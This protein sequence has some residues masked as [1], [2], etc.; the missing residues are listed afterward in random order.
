MRP[1]TTVVLVEDH[2]ALREGIKLLL[3]YRGHVIAGAAGDARSGGELIRAKRPDVA[4]VDIRLPDASGAQ[5]TRELLEDDPELGVLIY[6]GIG[7]EEELGEALACGARGF[8]LKSGS[9]E[10]L[11]AAIHA[12]AA[13]GTYM[14]P[15]LAPSLLARLEANSAHDLSPREREILELLADGLTGAQVAQLLFVSPETVR[16]HIRNAMTKLHAHTR[17]HAVVLALR[18]K[19]IELARDPVR[20]P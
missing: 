12:V 2:L 8:A 1:V 6:T 16:T 15:R 14:D 19:E 18:E 13:G 17:A 20:K 4:L 9:P 5:L 7:D 10:E 3:G 11:T